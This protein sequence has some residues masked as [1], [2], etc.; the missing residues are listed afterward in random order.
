MKIVFVAPWGVSPGTGVNNAILGLAGEAE[1]SDILTTG[2]LKPPA[3]QGWLCLPN[4][5]FSATNAAAFAGKLPYLLWWLWSYCRGCSCVNPHFASLECLPFAVLRRLRLIPCLIF[6]LHGTDVDAAVRRRGLWRWLARWMYNSADAVTACSA[7]LAARAKGITDVPV[8]VVHNGTA[9]PPSEI[10]GRPMREPYVLCVAAYVA[11][12]AHCDLLDAFPVVALKHPDVRLVMIGGDG[13]E[14][15]AVA[16]RAFILGAKCFVNLSHAE[17][18]R[19]MAHAEC[20]VLPSHDEPFGIVLLEAAQV[21]TP[22][23]ATRVGGIPEFLDH[24]VHGLLCEPDDPAALAA[25]IL[26]TLG[27]RQAAHERAK[28]FHVR[29]GLFTWRAAYEKLIAALPRRLPTPHRT[30]LLARKPA[31]DR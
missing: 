14:R 31:Q 4:P 9:R 3:G 29:A 5:E 8:T 13:P 7:A 12:K 15:Q 6:S 30:A 21:R 2:W 10:G 17:T 1:R 16:A 19:W 25:A 24:G 27:D 28:R 26:E 23:V 20:L 22:V 18:W 11:K